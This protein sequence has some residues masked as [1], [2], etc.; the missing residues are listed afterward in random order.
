MRKFLE[1]YSFYCVTQCTAG[2]YRYMPFKKILILSYYQFSKN[3][4]SY[5]SNPLVCCVTRNIIREGF[6]EKVTSKVRP[7]GW[8][9]ASHRKS[10][11]MSVLVGTTHSNVLVSVTSKEGQ[12]GEWWQKT[13][14]EWNETGEKLKPDYNSLKREVWILFWA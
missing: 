4:K 8:V 6:F 11:G 10:W 13:W 9:K 3:L 7:K 2:L 14:T 1:I 5:K 12:C